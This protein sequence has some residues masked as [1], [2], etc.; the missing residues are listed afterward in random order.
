[1]RKS[2]R[3]RGTKRMAVDYNGGMVA[4]LKER[5]QPGGRQG[6]AVAVRV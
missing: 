1:M 5:D 4:L 6:D 2:R 3:D